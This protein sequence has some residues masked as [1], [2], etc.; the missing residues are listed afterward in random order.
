[1]STKRQSHPTP[2]P[3]SR[4]RSFSKSRPSRPSS[5]QSYRQPSYEQPSIVIESSNEE[6]HDSDIPIESEGDESEDEQLQEEKTT[7]MREKRRRRHDKG[8]QEDYI[9]EGN[10]SKPTSSLEAHTFAC[11]CGGTLKACWPENLDLSRLVAAKIPVF[12][13]IN[14]VNELADSLA[15]LPFQLHYK[16]TAYC[17][18][19]NSD[20]Q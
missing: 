17:L 15:A 12:G 8:Q 2:R 6:N 3:K 1:M 16:L 7:R 13:E 18:N 19:G 4:Q 20:V 14:K 5:H 10:F 11:P 9:V